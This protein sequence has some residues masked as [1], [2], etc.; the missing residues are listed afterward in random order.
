MNLLKKMTLGLVALA[1]PSMASAQTVIH[2][3]GSTAFRAPATISILSGLGGVGTARAVYT[4]SSSLL[5]ST[6][7]VFAN[8]T[9]GSGGTATVIVEANWTGSLAG[10]VDLSLGNALAFP[11]E[12]DS[13]IISAVNAA[14]A[15]IT[16]NFQGGAT[17]YVSAGFAG[18][19]ANS[20][21]DV[22]F[23][24]AFASSAAKAVSN[25]TITGSTALTGTITNGT[26][27]AAAI[28][29]A[30]LQEAGSSSPIV[31]GGTSAGYLGIVPFQWAIGNLAGSTTLSGTTSTIKNISQQTAAFL[32]KTGYAPLS[33]FSST[34]TDL[35]STDTGEFVY[36]IGRNEDSGTRIDGF[37]EP[38]LGFTQAPQQYYI[39][40]SGGVATSTIPTPSDYSQIGVALTGTLTNTS[41]TASALVESFNPWTSGST[42]NT[43]PRITWNAAGHGGYAGGG[44][45]A[46]TLG[47]P[48]DQA[49]VFTNSTYYTSNSGNA[50]LISY[51]GVSDSGA[52]GDGS[53]KGINVLSYNGVTASTAGVQNGS[54]SFWSYEHEYYLSSASTAVKTFANTVANNIATTY[55]SYGSGGTSSS[56]APSGVKLLT[57]GTAGAVKRTNEGGNYALNY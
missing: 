29:A 43:E 22:A 16:T 32:I 45:V 27:L 30:P 36:L 5:K 1:L 26:Q 47:T 17:G 2:V 18:H 44:D 38:Q 41:A 48:V 34:G 7:G 54:Y 55:I 8:G 21:A 4:G 57:N 46:A 42:L 3:T 24:D 15:I 28:N 9:I 39:T 19:T 25:A 11:D 50:Y 40:F 49:N 13:T 53:S 52:Y 31:G 56:T 20:V 10:V 14:G 35:A 23:T 6:S 37:A 12:T 33:L 51:L